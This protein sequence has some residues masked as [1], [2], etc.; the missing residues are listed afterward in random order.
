MDMNHI[1]LPLS[2]NSELKPEVLNAFL[3]ERE[4][5]RVSD[6][7]ILN[8]T[9]SKQLQR[10][11]SQFHDLSSDEIEQALL[12]LKT[13][14]AVYRAQRLKQRQAGIK[15]QCSP[16]TAEQ[17]QQMIQR[18]SSQTNEVLRPERLMAK[19]LYMASRLREY[20]IYVRATLHI[21]NSVRA[22]SN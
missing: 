16:P 11:F 21:S 1:N 3:R 7:A 2:L 17:L 22:K 6:W 15:G 20:R 8:D 4:G 12:L 10:V 14:H 9:S 19:L 13:Y 18:L 5:D